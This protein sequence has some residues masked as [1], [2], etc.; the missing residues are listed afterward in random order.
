M[1]EKKDIV[2]FFA[3]LE[4]Q[5]TTYFD[6]LKVYALLLAR[7]WFVTYAVQN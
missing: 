5:M 7:R 2:S 1:D 3:A 4:I 6:L